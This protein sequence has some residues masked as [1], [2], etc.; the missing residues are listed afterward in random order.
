[1]NIGAGSGVSPLRNPSSPSV[2]ATATSGAPSAAG[3]MSDVVSQ[4]S[5]MLSQLGGSQNDDMM[6]MLIALMILMTL[7]GQQQQQQAVP[8]DQLSQLAGQGQQGLFFSQQVSYTSISIE[9]T[10]MTTSA[11]L[12]DSGTGQGQ[13]DLSI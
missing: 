7:M 5:E 1:M 4:L 6:K 12:P 9:Q 13:L 2:P 3:Q 11:Y 10:T 8:Q